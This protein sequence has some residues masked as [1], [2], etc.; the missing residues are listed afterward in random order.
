MLIHSDQRK[1]PPGRAERGREA[2]PGYTP[3]PS[4]APTG[5]ATDAAGTVAAMRRASCTAAADA[6]ARNEPD[7]QPGPERQS[8]DDTGSPRRPPAAPTAND[9]TQSR[10][11]RGPGAWRH[12][13]ATTTGPTW[14]ARTPREAQPE[15]DA[16]SAGTGAGAVGRENESTG[17]GAKRR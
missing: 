5:G 9:A 15:T 1:A 7:R 4:C 12:T 10:P 8:V 3:S 14:T 13:T 6:R 16:G 11:T 17:G 2:R